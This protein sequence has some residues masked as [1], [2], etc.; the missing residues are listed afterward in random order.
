MGIRGVGGARGGFEVPD[1]GKAEEA[2]SAKLPR[3]GWDDGDKLQGAVDRTKAKVDAGR[4]RPNHRT[5]WAAAKRGGNAD[6]AG[7][8][9]GPLPPSLTKLIGGKIKPPAIPDRPVITPKYG[10]PFPGGTGGTGGIGTKPPKPVITPKYGV[11]FPGGTGGTGGI[12]TKPP[13]PIIVAKYGVPFPGGHGGTGGGTI[14]PDKPV[15][16]A[17]YGVPF[18]G[19]PGGGETPDKPVIVAKYGVPFPGSRK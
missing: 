3:T 12:G 14:K 6:R 19:R 17:K 2:Q 11:P 5:K 15:I 9:T 13:K 8:P 7:G 10:V 16:V 4:S 1:D 18:P